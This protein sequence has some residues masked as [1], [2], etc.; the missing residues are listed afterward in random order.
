MG[1]RKR[2]GGFECVLDLEASLSKH[3]F[4]SV[5]GTSGKSLDDSVSFS[6][7]RA[8]ISEVRSPEELM[9]V[10]AMVVVARLC[11]QQRV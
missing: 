7:R 1:K 10:V 2:K 3:A 8:R 4:R 5:K 9:V 11:C 6:D